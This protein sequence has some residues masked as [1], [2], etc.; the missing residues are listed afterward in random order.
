[1]AKK[2]NI[3]KEQ[4]EERLIYVPERGVFLRRFGFRQWKVGEEV[5]SGKHSGWFVPVGDYEYARKHLVWVMERR[6]YPDAYLLNKNGDIYDDRIDNLLRIPAGEEITRE[7]ALAIFT[8]DRERG[9]L[10]RKVKIGQGEKGSK[11]SLMG[12]G[13]YA[14]TVGRILY[15][16][17]RL[18]WL[19]EHGWWPENIDHINGVRTDN[20]LENL[21]AVTRRENSRNV[22]KG[23]NATGITGVYLNE[24][25]LPYR[26]RICNDKGKMES[27]G[28]FATLEEAAEARRKAEARLG[29]HPNHGKSKKERAKS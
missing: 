1:M 29:Y 2:Q 23:K 14:F 27:L 8:Y 10:T 17:H 28:N 9:E 11:G 19:M 18:I 25:G 6:A 20:R 3:T 12:V 7:I 26:A 16:S 21:R 15:L 4:I 13:Y 24:R 22:V 5:G